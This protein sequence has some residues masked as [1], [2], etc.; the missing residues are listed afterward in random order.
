MAE[1]SVRMRIPQRLIRR[2]QFLSSA[3]LND[4]DHKRRWPSDI[5]RIDDCAKF[6]RRTHCRH[7]AVRTACHLDQL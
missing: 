1:L 4:S 2:D 6:A 5:P 7:R 3:G